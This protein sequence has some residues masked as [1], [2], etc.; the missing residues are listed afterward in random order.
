MP[1]GASELFADN[2]E[3]SRSEPSL[4]EPNPDGE[5]RLRPAFRTAARSDGAF[6]RLFPNNTSVEADT[7]L[8]D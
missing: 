4:E 2:H 6:F 3:R 1:R 5:R 8:D 7:K